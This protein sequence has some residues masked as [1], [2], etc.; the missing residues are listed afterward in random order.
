MA[1]PRVTPLE[2]EQA[3]LDATTRDRAGEHHQGVPQN[4][5]RALGIPLKPFEGDEID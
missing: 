3:S 4:S 2:R 5:C 1:D